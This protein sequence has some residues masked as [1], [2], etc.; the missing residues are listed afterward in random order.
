MTKAAAPDIA[1]QSQNGARED[2]TDEPVERADDALDLV[3]ISDERLKE[4]GLL[5]GADTIKT[6]FEA[7]VK[8]AKDAGAERVSRYASFLI[9]A[10]EGRADFPTHLADVSALP[11]RCWNC[12]AGAACPCYECSLKRHED[13]LA[14]T[15]TL[16]R[17]LQNTL[18]ALAKIEIKG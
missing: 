7:R 18:L 13:G 6:Q 15:T 10:Q 5:F 1:E 4:M 3:M 16:V 2:H 12:G 14:A 9:D 11:P 17:S 8:D